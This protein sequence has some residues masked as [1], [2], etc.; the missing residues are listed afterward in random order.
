MKHISDHGSIANGVLYASLS[1]LT[2]VCLRKC[3][4]TMGQIKKKHPPSPQSFPV[5]GNLFSIPLEMEHIAY[6]KLGKLL[7]TD[8]VFLRLF[9]YNFIVINSSQVATDLLDKR[10]ALYSDRLCPPMVGDPTLM[11]WGRNPVLTGYNDV[12]RQ[13][14]RMMNNWLNARAVTQFHHIQEQQIQGLLRRLLLVQGDPEPFEKVKRA[15]F[16]NAASSMLKLAYGYTLE[17]DNDPI[18]EDIQHTNDHVV[19]AGMFTNFLVNIFPSL[20]RVPD[21]FPGTGWK[22]TAREWGAQKDRS[23]SIPYEWT[24]SQM[25]SGTAETSILSALLQNQSLTSDLSEAERERHLKEVAGIIVAAGTDTSSTVLVN[26][27]A[28][29][30]S[31]PHVQAKA[32]KELDDVLGPLSLPTMADRGRLPYIQNLIQEV[33]RWQPVTPTGIPHTCWNDDNYKGYQIEKGTV[34]IG[35][36]WA[37]TR[38]E[39][40]YKNPETFDP[41]RFQDPNLPY[42]PA[43][44]W[45]RRKC[46]GI[47]FAEASLFIIASSLLATFT[48]SK[49]K[50][51]T[52]KTIE[53]Q[54]EGVSNA[55]VLELKP[56]DFELHLRSA[57]HRRLILE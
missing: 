30:V 48:F 47:H 37:M 50:D 26:F 25:A 15:L 51:A 57:D 40:I 5:V 54:I 43:F 45:G 53:P 14:R 41:D 19:I 21:W 20:S 22:R 46:P 38:D 39:K 42:S 3:W 8:I 24:K 17:G 2:L 23:Q 11:D 27:V 1:A 28:A 9:G 32:Q 12:W 4:G 6:T 18:F 7:N 13:Y 35:N 44:G 34:V 29:M 49:K 52:G 55:I 10:S 56:F 33:L 36:L 16:Y 31:N